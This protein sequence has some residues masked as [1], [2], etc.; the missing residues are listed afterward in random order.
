MK[1][2]LILIAFT[3]LLFLTNCAVGPDFQ[4]PQIDTLQVYRYD[5]L[6]VIDTLAVLK[7]WE[8]FNDPILDTLIH[9]ALN[10][11]RD[12]RIA[13]A[14][15]Q[16]ARANLGFTGA[17][18]YPKLDI[19]AG[20]ARGNYGVGI[21]LPETSSN[22]FITPV[23]SWE[24]DFWGKFS[25]ATESAEA[26]LLASEYS[27][28]KVQV[29]LISEVI[30]TYFLLLDYAQ[31]LDISR[32]TLESRL[33]SLDIIQQRFDQGIIPEIDLNQ[34][35]IQKEIAEASIPAYERAYSQTENSLSILLGK[36]PGVIKNGKPLYEQIVP[37]EIPV[38]LPS[39]LLSRRPDIAE[40]EFLL[41]AQNAQ[42]GV[43]V[44]QRFPSISL[45]GIL[46]LASSDLSTLTDGGT[47]WSISGGL[48]GPIFNFNKNIARV[49]VEEARTEQALYKYENTV[50]NA[51]RE[52]EDA[53]IG[54][55][56]YSKQVASIERQ[57]AAADNASN[58]SRDRYNQGV[59]SY[60]EVQETERAAFNANLELSATKKDYL[61]AYVKLYKALGGGWLTEEEM[62]ESGQAAQE[63]SK[64]ENK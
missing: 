11:N 20:A 26:Q 8:L 30:G 34:A 48:L 37:P 6:N 5:S 25:R 59:T 45:T 38:G 57:F 22:F 60:L 21:K 15:I 43:A 32:Q 64:G 3:P 9:Q 16:E 51:F 58:L 50:L 18:R 42:V 19:Q 24:I 23:L 1:K 62:K 40:A 13:A 35:Q 44:A 39:Q 2:F 53:L 63:A 4:K 46:G 61:N 31:R 14:R 10:E 12:L 33:I 29:S 36:N 7:W 47:A 28:R 41:M 54:I 52:V 55:E 49:E 27:L 17:D 56:T